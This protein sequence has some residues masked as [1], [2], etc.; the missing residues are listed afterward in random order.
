MENYLKNEDKQRELMCMCSEALAACIL[1]ENKS[2]QEDIECTKKCSACNK[3]L[4]LVLTMIPSCLPHLDEVLALSAKM[5]AACSESCSK[6]ES[7][8]CRLCAE[9]CGTWSKKVNTLIASCPKSH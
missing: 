4:Y 6:H 8:H 7:T 2:M 3:M 5:S 9:K 1:C